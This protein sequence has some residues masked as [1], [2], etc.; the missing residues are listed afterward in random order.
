MAEN[1]GS[2]W[3]P[4]LYGL[5]AGAIVGGVLGILLAPKAGNETRHDI[6]L[7]A[8]KLRDKV[9]RHPVEIGADS[10]SED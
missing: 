8:G 4:L 9:R 6:A 5:A 1:N 2:R 7:A 3:T 10:M